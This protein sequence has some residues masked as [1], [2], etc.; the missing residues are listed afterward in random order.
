[1]KTAAERFAMEL[2]RLGIRRVFGIPGGAWIEYMEALRGEGVEFVLVSN[3]ASAGFMA[4]VSARITGIPG[5]CYGTFGPGAT[6]LASGVAGAL[7]DRSPVLAFT[8][9]MGDSMLHRTTQMRIDHQALFRPLTKWTTRLSPE[10]VERELSEAARVALSEVPGP[11]H[12][13]IPADMGS[14]QVKG[15]EGDVPAPFLPPAAS[16]EALGTMVEKF[17]N[18]SR[19]VLAA[20]LGAVRAGVGDLVA[21]LSARCG[22][23]VVLTPMAKGLVPDSHPWFAGVLFHAGS[24][25]L[26][27]LHRESDLVVGIGYDPV[28]FNYEEWLP[29]APLIHLDTVSADLDVEN[30]T[31][32]ADVVGDLRQSLSRLMETTKVSFRWDRSSVRRIREKI[33]ARIS[34]PQEGFGPRAAL[35]VLRQVLPQDGVLAC[36]VGAH[37]HLIGQMWPTPAPGHLIMTNGWSSMGFGIPAAIAAKI[38]LPDRPAA[39]VVGDGGFLMAVGEMATA[40]RMKTAVVFVLLTDMDLSLIRVK[41]DRSG[42]CDG[43]GTV[44]HGR[45]YCSSKSFFG[46]P[47]LPARD[48]GEF[49]EVLDEA[50]SMDGPVIVE[51][52]VDGA[53]YRDLIA[54]RYR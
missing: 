21:A 36:D 27:E 14:V 22:L 53:E 37:T 38:C 18:A 3:E 50:F 23:P 41:Q 12:V 17:R 19:P 9:E 51:A 20:G 24:D 26:C 34:P 39:C 16:D 28:E 4:D 33:I 29:D 2:R 31:L 15:E 52:F 25:L 10:K 45:D 42:A 40:L 46:V 6:N 54:S 48:Q 43:Y 30:F 13:G 44:V 35:S 32:A 11:V 49:R 5:A 1:M 8:H 47:V 7:L